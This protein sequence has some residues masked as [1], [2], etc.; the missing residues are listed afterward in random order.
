M[1]T[2]VDTNVLIDV[3][4]ADATHGPAS[5]DALR[6]AVQAGALIASEVVWAET[7]AWY[8][9]KHEA[10]HALEQ[11]RVRFVPMDAPAAFAAGAA[12]GAYRRGGGRRDRLI[13]DFL[14]GAHATVHADRLLT[15]D[16]G[17]YRLGFEQLRIV[18]PSVS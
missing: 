3:L 15:R 17:F 7:S 18:D 6:E 16:A 9:S 1:I 5:R 12:W 14:V 2:A 8:R 4:G 11:L 10:A 13:A